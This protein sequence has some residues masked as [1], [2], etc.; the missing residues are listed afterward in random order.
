[1]LTTLQTPIISH[2]TVPSYIKS[3]AEHYIQGINSEIADQE[4]SEIVAEFV[5]RGLSHKNIFMRC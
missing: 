2:E 5:V 1:M 4:C 3:I